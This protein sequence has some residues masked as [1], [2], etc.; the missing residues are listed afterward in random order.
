MTVILV[1]LGSSLMAISMFLLTKATE[2]PTISWWYMGGVFA[3]ITL[4]FTAWGW[5]LRREWKR[6]KIQ[7]QERETREQE[8]KEREQ[9][10]IAREKREIDR[11]VRDKERHEVWKNP[12]IF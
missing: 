3:S 7:E 9:R 12:K 10:E 5:A 1:A 11:E 4:S 8:E 6:E 2:T